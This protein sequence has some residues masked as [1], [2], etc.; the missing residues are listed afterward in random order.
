MYPVYGDSSTIVYDAQSQG[1]FYLAV[2]SDELHLLLGNYPLNLSDTELAAYQ[3]TLYGGRLAYQSKEKTSYGQPQT[4]VELFGAE[5][6]QAHVHDE[7]AA[8]GT[9][10]YYLSHKNLIEGSEQIT[11]AIRDKN[12]GLLLSSQTQQQGVDYTIKYD[13]GRVLFNRPISSVSQNTMLINQALL[14]GNPVYIEIDYETCLDSFEKTAMGGHVRKQ[15]GDHLAVGGTYIK[16]EL[17]AGSYNLAGA[18]SEIRLG[19]STRLVAEFATSSGNDSLTYVSSDGGITYMESTPGGDRKGSAWKI[20]AETDVGEWFGAAGK[21]FMSGYFKHVDSGFRSNGTVQEQGSTKYGLLGRFKLTDKDTILTRFDR[22][23][24]DAAATFAAQ[25]SDITNINYT[26]DQ[27]RWQASGEIQSSDGSE[28]N[29]TASG[30]SLYAAARLRMEIIKSLIGTV[31]H[32]QTVLGPANNQSRIGA[33]YK[34]N[35]NLALQAS[36]A[37]GNLGTAGETGA[38]VTLYKSK[39]YLKERLA[40]D[41]AG[42]STSTI[43]GGEQPIG[44]SSKIYTEYQWGMLPLVTAPSLSSVRRNCGIFSRGCNCL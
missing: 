29:G 26:H 42:R 12:T 38:V 11:I 2:E 14:A 35:N 39:I 28:T 3:R 18:D 6:R 22:V 41:Q 36:G 33:E 8:T 30:R 37:V 34:V 32:Q 31:E 5:L 44:P 10:L 13:Q 43:V 19:K 15:F 4:K 1:K 16:D 7:L 21:N 40:D 17:Q 9:S 23:E 24:Q 25:R 27:G 20:A